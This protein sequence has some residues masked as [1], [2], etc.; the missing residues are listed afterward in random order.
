MVNDLTT[1]DGSLQELID[2]LESNLQTMG[3][4][5]AEFDSTTGIMG[6]VDE[7]LDIQTGGNNGIIEFNNLGTT[8]N[9]MQHEGGITVNFPKTCTSLGRYC[10]KDVLSLKEI[11]IPST[12]TSLGDQSPFEGCTNLS[13]ITLNDN[14]TDIPNR[15]FYGCTSLKTIIFPNN[16]NKIGMY[17]FW[18]SGLESVTVPSMSNALELYSFCNCASL[19]EAVISEG[20]TNIKTGSFKD[21]INLKTVSLPSTLTVIGDSCFRNCPSLLNIT[22]PNAVTSIGT[23][24]FEGSTNLL[25]YEFEWTQSSNILTYDSSKMP[26]N[27]NA[28]IIVPDGTTSLYT[29]ENYPYDN[30][31]EKSN[32][33]YRIFDLTENHTNRHGDFEIELQLIYGITPVDDVTITLTGD[34]NSIRTATTDEYGK[35]TF[36]MTNVYTTV[37]YTATYSNASCTVEIIYKPYL[38]EDDCTSASGLSN[39]SSPLLFDGFT[40]VSSSLSVDGTNGYK[41]T[42]NNNKFLY[43]PISVLDGLDNFTFTCKIRMNNGTSG[44]STAPYIGICVTENDV[45]V[46]SEVIGTRWYSVSYRYLYAGT[47]QSETLTQASST[48]YNYGSSYY[49]TLEVV[50]DDSNGY[51]ATWKKQDGTVAKTYT[52]TVTSA[53]QDR[54]YGIWFR[55]GNINYNGFIKDIVVDAND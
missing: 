54:H 23:Y 9:Y 5:D 2:T 52:G 27:E 26:L 34:D 48:Y 40:G 43:Y 14:I 45:N 44:T 24:C 8:F 4:S 46:N 30:I 16:I 36:N 55:S 41:I 12:I 53:K 11:I 3:V 39:Y 17:S 28:V 37:E 10:F 33:T 13:S 19:V 6:L 25:G 38:L 42:H 7:I 22:I 51:T 32:I 49:M 50:F 29:S 31:I 15:C 20:N 47:L 1:L 21:C 35:V 18:G